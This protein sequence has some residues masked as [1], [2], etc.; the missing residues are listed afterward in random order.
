M[1]IPSMCL[2]NAAMDTLESSVLL[3]KLDTLGTPCMSAANVLM[4][5][6]TSL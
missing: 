6:P 3:A 5:E 2:A 1:T 4:K